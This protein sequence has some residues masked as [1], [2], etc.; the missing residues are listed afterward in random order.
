[1]GWLRRTFRIPAGWAGRR[2]VLRFQ[3]V[4][5]EYQVL[6]NGQKAG[7]FF[8]SYM[9]ADFDITALAHPGADNELLV[10]VRSSHLFDHQSSIY[11]KMTAPYPPGS[12]TDGLVGIWQDVF[13]LGLPVVRVDSVFIQPLVDVGRLN[14]AVAIRNDTPDSQDVTVSGEVRPWT[15]LARK[16]V[17]SAPEPKWRLEDPV[18]SIAA[19]TIRL[20]PRS[21]AVV[22]LT[23]AVNGRLKAWSPDAP[24]LYDA[25]LH[26]SQANTPVDTFS[27][28]FGWRKVTIHG[29]QVLLNGQPIRMFGDLCHPFG[30]F[31]MSRRFAWAWFRTIKQFGGNSVRLHAQP[32][33]PFYLDVADEMGILV[34]DETAVFGSSIRLNPED[35]AF[36]AR[37][38]AHYERLVDRDRNHPSVFGW[39]FGNEM[40][41]IPALNHMSPADTATYY[42]RLA[43][44]GLRARDWDPTRSWTSCDGDEDLG[45]RLPVWSK[46]YGLGLPPLPDVEKPQMVGE[47]GGS[48]YARPSQLAIFNGDRAYE[49]YVGRN[50][51]LAI[52]LYD[53]ITQMALPKLAYFSP[54]ELMWFGLEPLPLGERDFSRLPTLHDGVFFGP[55]VAGQPG[56]QPERIPPYCSTLNPGWDPGLPFSRPLP[57]AEAMKAALAPGGPAPCPWGKRPVV[58][59]PPVPVQAPTFAHAT[60]IG[61]LAS[62]L[63]QRLGAWGVPLSAAPADT[64]RPGLAIVDLDM[65]TPEDL[66]QARAIM[67]SVR[68]QG[69]TALLM[70]GAGQVSTAAL[71]ALL[72]EPASLTDQ[73]ATLLTP[74]GQDPLTASFTLPQLYFAEDGADRLIMRHGVSGPFVD[75]ARVLLRASATDWSLFNNAPENAKCGAVVLY[76]QLIKPSGVALIDAPWGKGQFLLCTLD[77][78]IA[79]ANADA[80]W[81]HLF[82]NMGVALNPPRQRALAAFDTAGALVNALAIG[83][84]GAASLVAA[85]ATDF[86]G[87]AAGQAAPGARAGGLAWAPVNCPSKDRFMLR[88]LQQTGPAGPFA[89]YFSFWLKSPRA[90]DD[91]LQGGPDSP[92]LNLLCY[93]SRSCQLFLDDRAIQPAGTEPADYRTLVTYERLALK[94]GW[95]HLILKVVSD[96]L[97][98]DQPATL[99]VRIGSNNPDYLA[100][101]ESAPDIPVA[102]RAG[103]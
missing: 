22:P 34:L 27:Q 74:D 2:L 59:R 55:Y 33:P 18:L 73:T 26:V 100:Q 84:F 53:N 23:V 78:R 16:D 70:A 45:G 99:A 66:P 12:N 20:A 85:S 32:Y 30:P 39:S 28:R 3:A 80:L 76:Q 29:R 71:D 93:V 52:D 60:F 87:Q 97:D 69:G 48:Y 83:R 94:Q 10:G 43:A 96:S 82:Q 49:S 47:S 75:H 37:Y 64:G 103:Q 101:I 51:A 25:V 98:G 41:A 57:M 62:I 4:A 68:N 44:L 1:M 11:P 90:L 24:N 7:Q 5:G 42:D 63:R 89:V 21:T 77:Y 54:S 14:L 8:D 92:R 91:L 67:A 72:P 9:P 58:V 88:E 56:M 46:H 6:V 79:T 102:G 61:S 19:R 13:L 81:I 95:N 35:P 38:A 40:F 86:L 31:M 65:L 17:L 15:S 36:W 50:E